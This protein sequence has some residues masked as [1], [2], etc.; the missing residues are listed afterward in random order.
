MVHDIFENAK[1]P[2]NEQVFVRGKWVSFKST[3]INAYC[4][5]HDYAYDEFVSF[6]NMHPI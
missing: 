5:L 3:N 1:E 6:Y 4:K 2:K